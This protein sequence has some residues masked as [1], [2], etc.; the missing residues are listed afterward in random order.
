M[1]TD[2]NPHAVKCKDLN[3]IHVSFGF[4]NMFNTIFPIFKAF[5]YPENQILINILPAIAAQLAALGHFS[6]F[7]IN[8]RSHQVIPTFH[9]DNT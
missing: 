3:W 8:W 6:V 4:K 2:Y 5:K 7:L 9:I 1:M